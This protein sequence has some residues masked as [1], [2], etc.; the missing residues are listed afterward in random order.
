MIG[1]VSTLWIIFQSARFCYRSC[2]SMSILESPPVCTISATMLPI[3]ADFPGLM[4]LTAVSTSLQIPSMAVFGD[5]GTF[6]IFGPPVAVCEYSSEQCSV[7]LCNSNTGLELVLYHW[8]L[9]ALYQACLLNILCAP[10]AFVS[11]RLLY[12]ANSN[13]L[14]PHSLVFLLRNGQRISLHSFYAS[15]PTSAFQSPW[16]IR[17]SFFFCVS[18]ITSWSCL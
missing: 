8:S 18:S 3:P 7:H 13:S 6:S 1:T 5:G 10:N 17:M 14:S 4:V 12:L 9:P 16:K 2:R 15:F 11:L